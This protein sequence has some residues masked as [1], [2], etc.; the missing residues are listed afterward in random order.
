MSP[1]PSFEAL[2]L[3]LQVLLTPQERAHAVAYAVPTVISAGAHLVLPG[4]T[5]NISEDAYLVF[6]DQEPDANWGHPAR[7]L[8]V[9]RSTGEVRS[10]PANLPPF[11]PGGGLHW[12]VV[13]KAPSVPDAAVASPQ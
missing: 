3:M 13:Y 2:V 5:I 9:Q 1:V 4:R 7:Y 6:V 10:I 12:R 11:R 8:V